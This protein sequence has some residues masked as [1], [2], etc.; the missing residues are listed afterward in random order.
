[1]FNFYNFLT[2]STNFFP[3][4]NFEI[5]LRHY[6]FYLFIYYKFLYFCF[7]SE[8]MSSGA[9]TGAVRWPALHRLMQ[10][11]SVSHLTSQ[12]ALVVRASLRLLR[13]SETLTQIKSRPL[14]YT[15]CTVNF[16]LITVVFDAI[17][18]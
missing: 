9:G 13:H 18:V 4:A 12:I 3:S 11:I 6:L 7:P 16:L 17:R 1:M 15:F 8:C 2:V 5:Y 10:Q 14:P